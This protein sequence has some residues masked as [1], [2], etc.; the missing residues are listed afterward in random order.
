MEA[1]LATSKGQARKDIQGGG[2][3]INN[4]REQDPKRCL[5]PQDLL[6]SHILLRKGKKTLRGAYL[7]VSAPAAP[8]R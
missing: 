6:F 2:A 5:K 8:E 4:V 3:N 7:Q 1:G